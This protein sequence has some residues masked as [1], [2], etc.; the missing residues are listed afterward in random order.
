MANLKSTRGAQWPLLVEFTFDV[1]TAVNDSMPTVVGNV[2]GGVAPVYNATPQ[3]IGG[4]Y[5]GVAQIYDIINLPPGATLIGGEMIVETAVVG[6]TA[7]GIGLG[8]TNSQNRYLA[9]TSMLA[10]GRTALT[11]T[12]YRGV[13]ENVRMTITNTV[14]IATAG[15]VTVR[16]LYSVQYRQNE[17]QPN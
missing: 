12:G 11:L 10:T 6:P 5:A 16:L 14:A 7:A 13:G 17:A 9:N 3:A 1:S 8:D 2:I 4:F 15:K